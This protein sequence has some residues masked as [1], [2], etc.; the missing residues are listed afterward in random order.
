MK[1]LHKTLLLSL[2]IA[3]S[4][5]NWADETQN[6]LSL[7]HI[8]AVRPDTTLNLL[9]SIVSDR[10]RKIY[11]Y[12]EY[13]Y[14]TSMK[15]YNKAEDWEL[16]TCESYEQTYAFNDDGQCIERVQYTLLSNG[17]RGQMQDKGAIEQDGIYTWER[18]WETTYDGQDCHL[19]TATAYDPWGNEVI[20]AEYEYDSSYD[21]TYLYKYEEKH[22]DYSRPLPPKNHINYDRFLEAALQYRLE[23]S[24]YFTWDEV[25]DKYKKVF[26]V[27][28]GSDAL[29]VTREISNDTLIIRKYSLPWGEKFSLEEVDSK[30]EAS[31]LGKEVYTLNADGTRPLTRY[32][33]IE[34]APGISTRSYEYESEVTGTWQWDDKGRL[35]KY[36]DQ[37]RC[38]TY[39]Y[40]DDYAPQHSLQET[41]DGLNGLILYPEEEYNFFGHIASYRYENMYDG[42]I[43]YEEAEAEY[44]GQGRLTCVHY[45]EGYLMTD[46]NGEESEQPDCQ[47]TMTFHYRADGHLDY[48]IDICNEDYGKTYYIKEVYIYDDLGTWTGREEYEGDSENGPWYKTYSESKSSRLTMRRQQTKHRIGEDMS[49]GYHNIDE[50]DGIWERRGIYSVVEGEIMN[51]YYE[52]WLINDATIPSDPKLNYTDPIMPLDHVDEYDA[53]EM[54]S[55][56]YYEWNREDKMWELKDAPYNARRVY[57]DGT[58][59]KCDHYNKEKQI[60]STDIYSFDSNGRLI[61]KERGDDFYIKYTYLTDDSNYLSTCLTYRGGASEQQ[62]FYYSQH[63]YIKPTDIEGV[64]ETGNVDNQYYDLQGRKVNHPSH[65]IYIYQGRKILIK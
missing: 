47:G 30:W 3:S 45:T 16:D 49:E 35:T 63:N 43:D 28:A 56:W 6:R 57:W 42:H 15:V 58:Q 59:V 22:Y 51:G 4:L 5:P 13:G 33:Y 60:T 40:A 37:D 2:V 52:E 17:Q 36:T 19:S 46:T 50:T 34:Y 24:E 41:M 27:S 65:G 48:M 12:N 8:K 14:I 54:L 55:C 31:D 29:K 39:T 21:D 9:D 7:R 23:G 20:Y 61:K 1:S 18:Y 44:D 53:Q 10:Y 25:N 32:N 62:R 11:Q 38:E 64:K 26:H